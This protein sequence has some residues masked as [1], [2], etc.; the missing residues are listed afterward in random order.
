MN[1]GS[2]EHVLSSILQEITASLR[3]SQRRDWQAILPQTTSCR[4]NR[5]SSLRAKRSNLS[6][7]LPFLALFPALLLRTL[8]FSDS[9]VQ[10]PYPPFKEPRKRFFH[11][12]LAPSGET[13][14]NKRDIKKGGLLLKSIL[15]VR[16]GQAEH[17]TRGLTGGWTDVDLTPVG[18]R[19]IEA[20]AKR[21]EPHFSGHAFDLVAS[22]LKR[23]VQTA[24]ILGQPFGQTLSQH[25]GLREMNN[26]IAAGKSEAEARKLSLPKTTPILDWQHYPEG[27]S[28]RQ[29][30]N[31]VAD[32]MDELTARQR[33]PLIIVAHRGTIINIL[34]WWLGLG[35]SGAVHHNF[36]FEVAPASL[37]VLR[38]NRWHE[39]AIERLN[40]TAHLISAGFGDKMLLDF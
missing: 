7:F 39:N 4:S 1:E 35:V 12:F 24:Q 19:Q 28:R 26:G 33:R 3:S 21:L 22:D 2:K 8:R 5:L 13:L 20:L 37:T 36:S 32:A 34:C 29:F 18:C 23:A 17:H 15:L 30:Y 27:E 14:Q 16:H 31:R 10:F 40:D 6:V 38:C 11:F 9:P 25:P